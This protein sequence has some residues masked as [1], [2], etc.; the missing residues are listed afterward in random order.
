MLYAE[1][2]CGST[3]AYET[4]YLVLCLFLFKLIFALFSVDDVKNRRRLKKARDVCC[5]KHLNKL[6]LC[7]FLTG[8]RIEV[9]FGVARIF[10]LTVN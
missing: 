10:R 4:H 5:K 9:I 7:L 6:L 2:L 1:I 8:Q 3:K